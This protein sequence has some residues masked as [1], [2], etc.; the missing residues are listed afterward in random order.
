MLLLPVFTAV[1]DGLGLPTASVP[2]GFTDAGL[3]IGMQL[4]AGP[5]QEAAVLRVA[6]AY[7]QLT[8]WHLAEPPLA[9]G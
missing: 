7:Q 4:S 9:A 3:P 2:I 6:D 8:D 5:W 1:W